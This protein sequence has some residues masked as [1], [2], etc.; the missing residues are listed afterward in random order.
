MK[1][2]FLVVV[3]ILMTQSLSYAQPVARFSQVEHDFGNVS[4]RDKV[5]HDFELSN[6][7]N[8][9]LL[10]EKVVASS[11][12]TKAV[13]SSN[14]LKPGEKGFIRVV[15]DLRG[16]KGIFSKGVEVY[17]NDPITPVATL[18][19]KIVVKD[20]I[21]MG[22]YHAAEIFAGDCRGCHVDQGVGKTGWDLFK[23]DCFMC[24]NA[25]KKSSL[26]TM[27]KKPAGEL[28]KAIKDGIENTLMPGFDIKNGGPLNDAEIKSLLDLIK[29]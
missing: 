13:S 10:I 25:G 28:L 1:R 3:F 2:A 7:G 12:S 6:T 9:D 14:L 18:S 16:K 11:G 21:H 23:A 24:H 29:S 20:Q 5:E 22:Q 19:L 17:T 15:V 8:E 26:S 27:S 4:E